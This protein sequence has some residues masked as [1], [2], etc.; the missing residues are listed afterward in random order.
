MIKKLIITILAFLSINTY[1]QDF[2]QSQSTPQDW[3][4]IENDF[5]QVIYPKGHKEKAI[6]MANLIEHYSQYVGLSYEIKKPKKVALIFRPERAEPNGFVTLAPRRT[7]WFDSSNFFAHTGT[8]EWLEILSIHEYRHVLQYDAFTKNTVQ[9]ADAIFGD[10]GVQILSF[11]ARQPWYME[12]DAVYAETKYTEAGRGISSRFL[13]R[14]KAILLAGETPTYDQFVSGSYNDKLVSHY[15]FGYILIS[16][17]YKTYGDNFWNEVNNNVSRRPYPNGIVGA[18][19]NVSGVDFYDFYYAA[20]EDIRKK[21]QKDA[22]PELEKEEYQVK[23]NA[24]KVGNNTYSINY[25]LNSHFTLKKGDKKLTDLAYREDLTRLDYSQKHAVFTQFVPHWRYGFKGYSDLT[26]I[27]LEDGDKSYI[28]SG[29][30]LYNPHFNKDGS[31]ILATQFDDDNTWILNEFDTAGNSLRIIKNKNYRFLEGVPLNN[32][33]AIAIATQKGGGKTIVKVNMATAQVT[34]LVPLSFNNFYWL[35]SNFKDSVLFEGQYQGAIEVFKLNVKTNTLYKCT[36]S[37]IAAFAPSFSG[38]DITYSE[39]TINGKRIVTIPQS[40][41]RTLPVNDLV[42]KNKWLDMNSPSDNYNNF[43]VQKFDDRLQMWTK[44]STKYEAEKK[45]YSGYDWRAFTPHSWNFFVGAGYGLSL[46]SDNYLRDFGWNLNLGYEALANTPYSSVKIDFKR[47][48][49]VLSLIADIREREVDEFG[50]INELGWDQTSYGLQV[51]LP[52]L[53]RQ[54]LY[55]LSAAVGYSAEQVI[56]KD[57]TLNEVEQSGKADFIKQTTYLELAIAKDFTARSIISPWSASLLGMYQ[58]AD[59]DDTTGLTKD[60]RWFGQFKLTTPGLFR[61][62]GIKFVVSGEKYGD[63]NG[64]RF[65]PASDEIVGN[66]LSRGYEYFATHRYVKTSTNY[67]FPL[68]YP[69]YNLKAFMYFK[70]IYMNLFYDNTEFYTT[71]NSKSRHISS[72]GTELIFNTVVFR[73]L[74]IDFGIRY[75]KMHEIDD[76]EVKLFL[77]TDLSF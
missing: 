12:G 50:S 57:Y 59:T 72:Y 28:T 26:L 24:Y 35:Q 39:E 69:D 20:F 58:D 73:A 11:L 44:N 33:E 15:L 25:D 76:D 13:T 56:T 36:D 49:P 75:S 7:E 23:T 16:Y 71:K 67:L 31:K 14:L 64:Y 77:G 29:L 65:Q 70:R 9:F 6:Y 41:C 53:G 51:E 8:L 18:I 60:Y 37:R 52:F 32:K 2:T 66:T 1:A 10:F 46:T 34:T 40:Q 19:E 5:V 54:N 42:A 55:T 21:W 68:F 74:P 38:S 61:N 22:F 17:G 62:N 48:W 43:K 45:E 27:D 63:G 30:R 4:T 47:Y 3:E